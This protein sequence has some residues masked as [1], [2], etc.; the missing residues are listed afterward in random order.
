MTYE[1]ARSIT[2]PYLA[3][4]GANA[5]IVGFVAGFGEL[6]GYGL[7]LVSGYLADRTEKYWMITIIGYTCNLLAV[8]LLAL[9]GHWWTAAILILLERMGKAIRTPPRDAMLSYAGQQTGMGFAFGLHKA[10]DQIGALLGPLIVAAVLYYNGN[11]R[12]AFA[13]LLVP[14]IFALILLFVARFLYPHPRELEIE[15]NKLEIKILHIKPFWIYLTA[16]SFVAAGFAD[17]PLIAFH[18][19][20]LNTLSTVWIPVAYAISMGVNGFSALI[21]GHLY[22]KMGFAILIFIT[23]ISS[24]F[25]P[26]VFFGDFSFAMAGVIL[27]GIGVGAQE[28]LMRAIV[29]KMTPSNK[30]ASAYGIFNMVYGVAWFLGSVTMGALYDVSILSLVIFSM[31]IQLA[32]IPLLLLV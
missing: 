17:F 7:R 23:F 12:E 9:S 22:D 1:G 19:A 27:W 20:K 26:L 6:I 10:L 15:T 5:L 13:I 32:S 8:P 16:A 25:A 21:L 31:L 29:A 24:F 3:F 14:A 4:L 30:R 11:Y 2:G 18:F 28:S